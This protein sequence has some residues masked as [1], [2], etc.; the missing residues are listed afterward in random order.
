MNKLCVTTK[1]KYCEA[2]FVQD[3]LFRYRCMAQAY[4]PWV[5]PHISACPYENIESEE[6]E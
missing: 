6:R 5:Y 1:C 3:E 2:V 4:T